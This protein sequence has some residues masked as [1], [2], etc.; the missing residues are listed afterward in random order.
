MPVS[1]WGW[2]AGH[3][4]VQQCAIARERP[5]RRA[6]RGRSVPA[7]RAVEWW[8]R[9]A[10]ASGVGSNRSAAP[11]TAL[12]PDAPDP[13]DFGQCSKIG[14][15]LVSQPF[16]RRAAEGDRCTDGRRLRVVAGSFRLRGSASVGPRG[17]DHTA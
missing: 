8:W 9:S 15:V 16:A 12:Q 17:K 4:S 7:S 6:R 10:R 3:E 5:C 11:N 2:L 13:A 14:L 1:V